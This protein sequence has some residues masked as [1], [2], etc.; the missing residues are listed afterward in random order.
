MGGYL[1]MSGIDDV[2]VRKP[3]PAFDS[4]RQTNVGL[5]ACYVGIEPVVNPMQFQAKE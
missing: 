2:D 3:Q 4:T 1:H 5:V